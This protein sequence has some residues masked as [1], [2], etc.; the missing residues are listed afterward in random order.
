MP[1]GQRVRE[2][3]SVLKPGPFRQ[4]RQVQT[5]EFIEGCGHGCPFCPA[6]FTGDGKPLAQIRMVA[7]AAARLEQELDQLADRPQAVLVSAATDPFPPIPQI[8]DET[9]RVVETLVRNDIDV[10]LMTRGFIRPAVLEQISRYA[11]RVKVTMALTTLDRP[12]QRL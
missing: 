11:A 6:R 10:W 7:D 9:A 3:G 12:L 5:V 1:V 4:R 8:Q 2:A